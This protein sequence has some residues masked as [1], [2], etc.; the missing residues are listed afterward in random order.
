MKKAEK[1]SWADFEVFTSKGAKIKNPKITITDQ[2]VFLFNAAFIHIA[3]LKQKTHVVL[4]YSASNK[5][6]TFDF[7]ADGKAQG[8]L[9]IVHKGGAASVGSRSFFNF[10][11]LTDPEVPGT[12]IPKKIKIPR[13]GEVWHI[14]LDNKQPEK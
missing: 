11:F 2:S 5:I 6:I 13:I 4:G 7:T 10:F 14:A 8:A 12:Y 1:D 9:K 3:D